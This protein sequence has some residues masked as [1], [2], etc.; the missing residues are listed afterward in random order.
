L[1]AF[2]LNPAHFCL[3]RWSGNRRAISRLKV[4]SW[5]LFRIPKTKS[6]GESTRIQLGAPKR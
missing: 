3:L 1:L 6:S 4:Q 2:V 5:F